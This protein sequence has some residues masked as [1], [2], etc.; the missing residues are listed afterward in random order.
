MK[1]S[2]APSS[3]SAAKTLKPSVKPSKSAGVRTRDPIDKR[4]KIVAAA[5]KLFARQGFERTTTREIAQAAGVAEGTIYVHFA[6]KSDILF[7]FF[8]SHAI[9]P[10]LTILEGAEG[11]DDRE[12]LRTLLRNRVEMFGRI[13]DVARVMF[14]EAIFNP[15]IAGM[16]RRELTECRERIQ[17]FIEEGI[18]AG[19]F[20]KLDPDAVARLIMSMFFGT[21]ILW[22]F[23]AGDFPN[24]FT[25][26]QVIETV[27]EFLL[28]GLLI[29]GEPA[30][31]LHCAKPRSGAAGQAGNRHPDAPDTPASLRAVH[32]CK[33]PLPTSRGSSSGERPRPAPS[34]CTRSTRRKS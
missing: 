31:R 19:R 4:R 9:A 10:I 28:G 13:K 33:R 2:T 7:E 20:R 15:K 22:G 26:D 3:R 11:L 8:Q 17:R 5:V 24:R 6:S 21:F 12:L 1:T 32:G 34:P 18:E 27:P 16:L 25:P 30:G 29:D 14:G 23:I